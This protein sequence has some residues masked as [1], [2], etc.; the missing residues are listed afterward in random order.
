M[1]AQKHYDMQ[2]VRHNT[3]LTIPFYMKFLNKA[4]L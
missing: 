2:E 3:L 4:N 1:K